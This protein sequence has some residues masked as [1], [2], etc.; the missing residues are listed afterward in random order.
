MRSFLGVAALT[1]LLVA[2]TAGAAP[3]DQDTSFSGDGELI[4]DIDG[5]RELGHAVT[6]ANGAIV[7]AGGY[8]AAGS[9][10]VDE[11]SRPGAQLG[12]QPVIPAGR[13]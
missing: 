9:G 3:G 11:L 5:G 2:D 8:R 4:V 7:V 6:I 12:A 1:L 13:G 10:H